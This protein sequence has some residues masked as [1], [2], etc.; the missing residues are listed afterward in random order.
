MV[1]WTDSTVCRHFGKTYPAR[2]LQRRP[3]PSC[4]ECLARSVYL[5]IRYVRLYVCM[6]VCTRA[7]APGPVD[8][9]LFIVRLASH[10]QHLLSVHQLLVHKERW[11]PDMQTSENL[12]A[13]NDRLIGC[14]IM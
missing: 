8:R 3:P 10:Y 1:H 6:Y 12:H 11:Q 14:V 5:S 2:P 9:L 4:R 13:P 7:P